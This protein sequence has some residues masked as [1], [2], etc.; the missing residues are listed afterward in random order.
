MTAAK[1]CTPARCRCPYSHE[2]WQQQ[3]VE[4]C[5]ALG[6]DHL[7]VRR[8][9]GK[10][11]R[12]VTATNLIGWPD[13]LAF[14]PG[15]FVGLELKVGVDKATPEQLAVLA[16]LAVAGARTM[17]AYPHHLEEVQALLRPKRLAST[18]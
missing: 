15:G 17:V 2:E 13:L 12:W 16:K 9:I 5:H 14:G 1:P 3:V 8:T 4:L 6:Y 10:G 7:H 11:R 18:K